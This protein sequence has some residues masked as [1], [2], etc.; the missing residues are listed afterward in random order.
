MTAKKEYWQINTARIA[1]E[2]QTVAS[3]ARTEEDLKM[4][5][6]PIPRKCEITVRGDMEL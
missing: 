4:R 3:G 5:V 2:I 6:E 1:D